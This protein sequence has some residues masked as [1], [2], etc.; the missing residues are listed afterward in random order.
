LHA[1]LLLLPHGCW[2]CCRCC[3]WQC[4]AGLEGP[5]L[6]GHLAAMALDRLCPQRKHQGVHLHQETA[7]WHD[8]TCDDVT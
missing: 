3:C 8:M 5:A 7:A 4:A 1:L 2:C 6:Q